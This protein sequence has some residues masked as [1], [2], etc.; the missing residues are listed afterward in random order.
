MEERLSLGIV[1]P[2][3]CWV[4]WAPPGAG[5]WSSLRGHWAGSPVTVNTL[6]PGGRGTRTGMVPDNVPDD[7]RARLL[8]PAVMGPPIVWL[9][10]DQAT[11]VHNRR[12]VAADFDPARIRP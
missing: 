8:D 11:G 6:L 5:A 1:H 3:R 4:K 9:A 2:R 12:I 7:V 10:S